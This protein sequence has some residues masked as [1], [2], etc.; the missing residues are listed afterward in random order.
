MRHVSQTLLSHS[1]IVLLGSTS[2]ALICAAGCG[3]GTSS[4]ADTQAPA[5]V[6]QGDTTPDGSDSATPGDTASTEVA[7]DTSASDGTEV[8]D[9]N[10]PCQYVFDPHISWLDQ[11][12]L[13][14]MAE[15]QVGGQPSDHCCF[16]VDSN[17]VIDNRIGE[18]ARLV[19][20]LPGINAK[21]NDVLATNI[22]NGIITVLVEGRGLGAAP[23]A[24]GVTFNAFY[25]DPD[26]VSAATFSVRLS[27]FVSGTATPATSFPGV[28]VNNGG[29]FAGPSVFHLSLPIAPGLVVDAD[30]EAARFEGTVASGLNGGITLAGKAGDP[31][32]RLGGYVP[33]D[34]LFGAFND[35]ASSQCQ[36][37]SMAG[38]LLN[39]DQ[40]Q[41]AC[42]APIDTNGCSESDRIEKQCILLGNICELALGFITPDIAS[43]AGGAIDAYSVGF[44]IT[45]TGAAVSGVAPSACE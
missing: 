44:W 17:G 12:A 14:S 18:I 2:L 39:K 11:L 26:P 29:F 27:S 35:Y 3:D 28:I 30:I 7:I 13:G 37:L 9:P 15:D 5:D 1:G 8:L 42:A 6:V 21:L 22:A 34:Q 32:A 19:Q 25:G 38:A 24:A 16:D 20:S 40:G 45:G 10:D 4:G 33:E 23:S 43:T 36:C 41:W 31:G